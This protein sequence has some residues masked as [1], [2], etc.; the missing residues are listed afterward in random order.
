MCAQSSSWLRDALSEID[1]SCERITFIANPAAD[2]AK[3]AGKR[4][5]GAREIDSTVKPLFRIKASGDFGSTE[6][7]DYLLG[8]GSETRHYYDSVT[9]RWITPTTEKSWKLLSV[10]D[11]CQSGKTSHLIPFPCSHAV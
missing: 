1:S 2:V 5:E 4:K 3:S 6:V 10:H 8:N 9:C 7:C 11:R